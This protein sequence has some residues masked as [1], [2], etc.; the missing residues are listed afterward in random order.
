MGWNADGSFTRANED[1]TGATVWQ[2]DQA[3]GKKVVASRHDTHDNV[4]ATGLEECINT[5]GYNAMLANLDMGTFDIT[6]CGD[7]T[8]TTFASLNTTGIKL[9][10]GDRGEVVCAT[11]NKAVY[12]YGGHNTSNGGGIRMFGVSEPTFPGVIQFMHSSTVHCQFTPADT[13]W[14]FQA[15][16]ITTTGALIVS[17]PT[18]D[19]AVAN[20]LYSDGAGGT[21][22]IS[23]G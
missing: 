1:Y 22:K 23:T 2:Q 14:D 9:G 5:S 21:V 17:L 12:V 19:P 18:S 16:D 11:S 10:S 4:I 15:N 3:A 20:Q 13:E 7:F 8:S 6:N